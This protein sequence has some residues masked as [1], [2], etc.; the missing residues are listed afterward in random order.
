MAGSMPLSHGTASTRDGSGMLL[1]LLPGPS[2]DQPA[3]ADKTD[4]P[5]ATHGIRLRITV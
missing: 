4:N 2:H 5:A 1:P 3:E